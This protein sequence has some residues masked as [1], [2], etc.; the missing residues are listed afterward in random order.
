MSSL[1]WQS[2]SPP[3]G[4]GTSVPSRAIVSLPSS[5]STVVPPPAGPLDGTMSAGTGGV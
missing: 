3:A 5:M 4:G 2:G 1:N